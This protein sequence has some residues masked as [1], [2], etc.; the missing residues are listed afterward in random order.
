MKGLTAQMEGLDMG[1][2][3][4]DAGRWIY[5]RRDATREG[6]AGGRGAKSLRL[7]RA[8]GGGWIQIWA[9]GRRDASR[10]SRGWSLFRCLPT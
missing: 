9:A 10:R 8:T 3:G 6:R 1:G 4:G 7:P 2:G 5:K